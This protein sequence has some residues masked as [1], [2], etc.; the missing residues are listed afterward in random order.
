MIHLQE[1]KLKQSLWQRHPMKTWACHIQNYFPVCICLYF[2]R[3]LIVTI[4]LCMF[5]KLKDDPWLKNRIDIWKPK[6]WIMAFPGFLCNLYQLLTDTYF[7]ISGLTLD[8]KVGIINQP[9]LIKLVSFPEPLSLIAAYKLCT[10]CGYSIILI[11]R[12]PFFFYVT[13]LR[14]ISAQ[15]EIHIFKSCSLFWWNLHLRNLI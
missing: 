13:K 11:I 12:L 7:K 5:K 1:C 2:V 6:I 15:L 3:L 14:Y 8:N 10:N 4:A 9:T